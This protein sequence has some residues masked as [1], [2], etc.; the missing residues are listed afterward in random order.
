VLETTFR[1]PT[2]T[3]R[4]SDALAFGRGERGHAI[5]RASPHRLLRVLEGVEGEVEVAVDFA[6]VL[7]YGLARPVLRRSEEDG[8]VVTA[9]GPDTLTLVP[10]R[11]GERF[12]LRAG[13]RRAWAVQ[14]EPGMRA[15]PVEDAGDVPGHLEDTAAAWR[16][17][18]GEHTDYDG[19]YGDAVRHATLVLQALTYAPSGAI[20]AAPTTS[21]P[22]VAGGEGNWDYRYAWLRDAALTVRA[23]WIAACPTEAEAFFAWMAYASGAPQDGERLQVVF[24]V[25]GE[26]DLTEHRLD[27][28]AGFDGA[29]P[30]RVGNEAWKQTQLDVPGEVLDAAWL[31]CD[32]M[33]RARD[34][35]RATVLEEGWHAGAGA[36]TGAF[37]SDHL[38]VAVLLMP[39][40]GIVDARDERMA[41]TI[42]AVECELSAADGLLRRWTASQGEGAFVLACYWLVECRALQGDVA[43]A[44]AL[45]ERIGAHANDVGLLSEM[46]DPETGALLGNM[47][48]GLA[49]IGLVNAAWRI[50]EAERG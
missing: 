23:L 9:G 50:G 30:V 28:L 46:I 36:Y 47:P 12:G 38:D 11:A 4:L 37:G 43:R 16:S 10:E 1:T 7:E 39:L 15:A 48:Q 18:A 20:V 3:V 25:E 21:L 33:A 45:F 6:P 31:L 29:T 26:R 40:V 14:H 5:G 22:E 34:E 41:A 44:R 27:H 13:E 49:H 8:R 2:G 42:D 32:A 19:P 35:V 24:G 17:W